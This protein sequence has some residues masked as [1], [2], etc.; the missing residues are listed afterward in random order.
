MEQMYDAAP[1]NIH[2]SERREYCAKFSIPLYY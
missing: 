1:I 2:E